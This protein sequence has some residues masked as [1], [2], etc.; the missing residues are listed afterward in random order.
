M[1]ASVG[2]LLIDAGFSKNA[3]TASR[4]NGNLIFHRAVAT[5]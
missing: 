3:R 2:D 1:R 4:Q 5:T